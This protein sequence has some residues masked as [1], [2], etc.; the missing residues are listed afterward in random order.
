MNGSHIAMRR[1]S[2]R[3]Y[4]TQAYTVP[5]STVCHLISSR[6][7]RIRPNGMM[8]LMLFDCILCNLITRDRQWTGL[9]G[10]PWG[11]GGNLGESSGVTHSTT[12]K[13]FHFYIIHIVLDKIN[14]NLTELSLDLANLVGSADALKGV[15]VLPPPPIGEPCLLLHVV[16]GLGNDRFV[17]KEVVSSDFLHKVSI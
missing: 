5:K 9:Q 3:R 16:V 8:C 1:I 2:D 14:V 4:A 17:Q 13:K 12:S 6:L 15:G 10:G 11:G 7:F